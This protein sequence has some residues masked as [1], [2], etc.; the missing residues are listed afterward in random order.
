MNIFGTDH[1]V[2]NFYQVYLLKIRAALEFTGR[3]TYVLQRITYK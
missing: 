3:V 2:Q 1:E